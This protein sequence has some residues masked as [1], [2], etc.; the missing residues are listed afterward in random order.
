MNIVAE[1]KLNMLERRILDKVDN[2][3]TTRPTWSRS[4]VLEHDLIIGVR[5]IIR[6]EFQRADIF[7][8]H[9][10]LDTNDN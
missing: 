9:N 1:N 3:F 4:P 2:L 5:Q 6:D 7:S 10:E 8:K